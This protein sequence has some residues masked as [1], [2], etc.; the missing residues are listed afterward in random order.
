MSE[1]DNGIMINWGDHCIA[2]NPEALSSHPRE[3]PG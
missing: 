1:P 2:L 3:Y